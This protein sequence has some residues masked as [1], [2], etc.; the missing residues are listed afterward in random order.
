MNDIWRTAV[1]TVPTPRGP[2]YRGVC[3]I[4]GVYGSVPWRMGLPRGAQTVYATRLHVESRN[5][6]EQARSRTIHHNLWHTDGA[7]AGHLARYCHE[8]ANRAVA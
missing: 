7:P 1:V 4:G 6:G 8:P 3:Y 5:A 2:R